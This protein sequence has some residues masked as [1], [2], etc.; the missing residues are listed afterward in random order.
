M[1]VRF[2]PLPLSLLRLYTAILARNEAG[3]DRYLKRVLERC[4]SFSD[5]VLLLDDRSTDHT[6]AKAR[7]HGAIVRI[8]QELD[9][10]AW[11]NE[12]S[13]RKELWD[14]ALEY[15]TEPD[16]WVL[17]NDADQIVIGDPRPLCET[18]CLNAWSFPLFDVWDSETTYR[19][20][21]FW[22]G[23]TVPRVWLIAPRRVPDGWVADWNPRGIHTGHFPHNLPIVAGNASDMLYWLHFGWMKES[24]RKAKYAQYKSQAHQLSPSELAHVESILA[25]GNATG[26]P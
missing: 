9:A 5:A 8:R 17:V 12:S 23:H 7:K 18:D 11:G 16:D 26:S 6:V 21:E 14:F 24:H 15:A 22:Q 20:D 10:R 19:S 13:A 25:S 1:R 4:A 3:P 2:S